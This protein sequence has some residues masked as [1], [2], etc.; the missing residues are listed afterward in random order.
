MK[1]LTLTGY[2]LYTWLMKFP[3]Q[4]HKRA[5]QGAKRKRVTSV[6]GDTSSEKAAAVVCKTK[7][8]GNQTDDAFMLE[9]L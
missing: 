5:E 2:L 6:S 1:Q 8:N 4:R 9:Y 7:N 3:F